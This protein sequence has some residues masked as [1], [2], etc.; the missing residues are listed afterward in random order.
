MSNHDAQT[1]TTKRDLT[2]AQRDTLTRLAGKFPFSFGIT[3]PSCSALERGGLVVW[4]IDSTRG[5]GGFW[6]LTD[7]GKAVLS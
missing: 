6:Q 3:H 7:A 4:N 1:P 2:Q 5:H